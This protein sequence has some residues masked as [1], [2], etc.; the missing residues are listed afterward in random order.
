M[1]SVEIVTRPATVKDVSEMLRVYGSFTQQFV[2][3]ASRSLKPFRSMLRKKDNV[4]WVALDRRNKIVGYVHARIDKRLNSGVFRE[5]VVDPKLSFE[6]V[7]KLLVERVHS[8]FM[9][10][11]VPAIIAGSLRNPVYERLFP[12]L[13]FFESESTDV[14]MYTI[15]N[16]EKFLNEISPV[17]VSRLKKL[18]K[19]SGLVQIECEGYS[20]FLEKSGD[21]VQQ[22]VWTNQLV[23]FKI[24]VTREVLTRLIFGIVDPVEMLRSGQLEVETVG[25]SGEANLLLKTFFPKLQ[26]LILD[27]W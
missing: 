3:S 18:E 9:E 15:L 10:K 23:D 26:F 12:R 25:G 14:F 4:T 7:A 1:T 11:K 21:G 16:V 22:I 6:Y 17:F 24:S 19:W 2:G 8:A 20:V 5:I 27:Y 13:G